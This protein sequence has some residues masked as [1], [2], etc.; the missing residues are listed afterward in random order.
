MT[1]EDDDN[2]D[3]DGWNE[4]MRELAESGVS[5]EQPCHFYLKGYAISPSV[6]RR[7][8]TSATPV[9]TPTVAG[10]CWSR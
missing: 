10:R 7:G 9:K 8:Y 2:F 4:M 3:D 1:F 5:S 6:P